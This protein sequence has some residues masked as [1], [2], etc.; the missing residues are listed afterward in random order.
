MDSIV[1]LP[2][3]IVEWLSTQEDMT[4]LKFFVEYPPIKKAV[5]LKNTIVAVGIEKIDIQDKFVENDDGVLTRQEYC[6]LAQIRANLRICVPFDLGGEA[7][8]DVF[9]RIADALTFRTNLNI[10]QSGCGEI[11]SDRDTDALIM[12]GWFLMNADFCPAQSTDENFASF[13][14]KDL[15]CGSHIRN[16]E[17]HVTAADKNKWNEMY[18][19]GFYFGDGASSRSFSL[20]FRPKIVIVAS[21][22][23]PCI[24]VDFSRSQINNFFA[25]ATQADSMPGITITSNGFRVSSPSED[26]VTTSLNSISASY[27]YIVFK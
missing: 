21:S 16:D 11:I 14:D 8:H 17:I 18:Q 23:S 26:R 10:E 13:L 6:R 3:R 2:I 4:D 25:I 7:C 19:S 5:P 15:L 24:N 1:S 27:F 20:G 12:T 9:T 22:E